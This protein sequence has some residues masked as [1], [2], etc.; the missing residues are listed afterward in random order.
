MRH[1]SGQEFEFTIHDTAATEDYI[2]Q[3]AT[4]LGIILH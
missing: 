2:L 3:R 4:S 1:V